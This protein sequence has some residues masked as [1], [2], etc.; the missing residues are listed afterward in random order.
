MATEIKSKGI[1]Y[2]TKEQFD[3]LMSTG[4]VVIG[5]VTYTYEDGWQYAVI[6]KD[7]VDL[8]T[9]QA[10]GGEKTFTDGDDTHDD[11]V[12][13]YSGVQSK[14]AAGSSSV[15]MT[16]SGFTKDGVYT[17]NLPAQN[18]TL[19]AGVY[20]H[21]IELSVGNIDIWDFV[22]WSTS[23]TEYT[24]IAA[25]E[26]DKSKFLGLPIVPLNAGTGGFMM[27]FTV[28]G[29]DLSIS[30]IDFSGGGHSVSLSNPTVLDTV[31]Q[32]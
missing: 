32:L 12:I 8:S 18:G 6:D 24:T 20:M 21:R 19:I 14:N 23:S 1:I 7:Y 30:A 9:N 10:V 26:A 4:S 3:T 17:L 13:D 2:C 28:S 31:I 15:K 11:V 29:T 5:G 22:F 27:T 25:L 16:K